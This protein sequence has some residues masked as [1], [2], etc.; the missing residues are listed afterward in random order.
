MRPFQNGTAFL[1]GDNRQAASSAPSASVPAIS[2]SVLIRRTIRGLPVVFKKRVPHW[3]SF[4]L[5]GLNI[6]KLEHQAQQQ[7]RGL[8]VAG[9]SRLNVDDAIR[10]SLQA[11]AAAGYSPSLAAAAMSKEIRS[12]RHEA[13]RKFLKLERQKAEL[14]QTALAER[15]GW[16]RTTISDIETGSKRVTAL[17]LIALGQALGFNPGQ[18][19]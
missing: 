6:G 7:G 13:L 19:S 18:V 1:F 11:I 12:P 15:L 5:H 2:L 4:R 3:A 17:E 14:N 10:A 16:D 9:P 8:H